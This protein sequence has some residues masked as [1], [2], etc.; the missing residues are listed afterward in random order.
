VRNRTENALPPILDAVAY[1]GMVTVAPL[2][3]ADVDRI[4]PLNAIN[5]IPQNVPVLILAAE[6]DRKARPVEA[7]SLQDRIK[8][9]CRLILFENTDHVKFLDVHPKRFRDAVLEFVKVVRD[10]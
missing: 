5:D 8:D 4:S 7:R 2:V 1:Q 10:S 6:N 9:H 3:L